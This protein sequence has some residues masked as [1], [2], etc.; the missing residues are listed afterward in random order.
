MQERVNVGAIKAISQ[1]Q[2][3]CIQVGEDIHRTLYECLSQCGHVLTWVRGPQTDY[4]K[5][6]KRK[7]EQKGA[8]AKSDLQRAMIAKPDAD[9]RSFIDQHRAIHRV[10]QA[11]EE[12]DQKLRA[13]KY[14]SRELERQLTLFR[15]GLSPLAN[16]AELDL[17]RASL[18]LKELAAHLDGYVKI[19]PPMPDATVLTEDEP[20]VPD[21]RRMGS[22]GEPPRDRD[23]AEED[24]R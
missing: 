22:T 15:G 24:P 7:R 19:A 10:K 14:W 12:S 9:P 16:A 4:W 3:K 18:W 8:T 2:G 5:R 11:I 17:P 23:P 20:E 1:L 21:H 13:V 6:Q